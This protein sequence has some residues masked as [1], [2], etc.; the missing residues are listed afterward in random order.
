VTIR[1]AF[2][3]AVNVGKRRVPNARAVKIVERRGGREVWAYI[4]SG[5][6]VFA[7]QGSRATIERGLERAFEKEFGFEVTTFIRT[8]TEL[9]HAL[10]LKP[11]RVSAGDTYFVTFLKSAPSAKQRAALE[12]LSNAFDTLVVDRGEVHWRM[13]GRSIE[14]K[15]T[16]KTWENIVGSRRSTSRNVT[17]LRK[18]VAKIESGPVTGYADMRMAPHS[19]KRS[20]SA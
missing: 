3:R 8:H 5:N 7:S 4:N 11:F 15:L 18:L 10:E 1:V 17:M 19:P 9:R 13:R 12:D 20:A 16:T 6:I 2:L 14:T